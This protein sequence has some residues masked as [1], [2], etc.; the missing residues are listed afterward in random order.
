MLKKGQGKGFESV[1]G[2]GTGFDSG[3]G[4]DEGKGKHESFSQQL[5]D[6]RDAMEIEMGDTPAAAVADGEPTEQPLNYWFIAVAQSVSKISFQLQNELMGQKLIQYFVEW[7]STPDC[8]VKGI[9]FEDCS[10]L[11]D[12]G[13]VNTT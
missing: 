6:V 13:G 11:Y 5:G 7:C 1:K 2:K 9:C 12:V 8:R 10:Y 4:K 3:K